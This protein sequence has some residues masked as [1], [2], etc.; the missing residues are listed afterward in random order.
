MAVAEGSHPHIAE[1][2]EAFTWAV[3]EVVTVSWVKLSRSDDFSQLLH[4][5]WLDVDYV[6]TL[7]CYI[8]MPQIDAQIICW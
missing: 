8:Q 4:V 7:I 5:G 1:P 6:E 2:D 3:N